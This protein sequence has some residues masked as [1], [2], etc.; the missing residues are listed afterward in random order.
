MTQKSQSVLSCPST[1][2]TAFWATIDADPDNDAIRLIFA[3]W[4][5]ERGDPRAAG[6]RNRCEQIR[7]IKE[8][9]PRLKNADGHFSYWGAHRHRY[10]LQPPLPAATLRAL[11]AHYGVRLPDDYF[12][13][14]VRIGEAGAG[15]SYGIESVRKVCYDGM[16][17][18]F[19]F[20]GTAGPDAA[21]D[22]QEDAAGCIRLAQHG[23]GSDAYLVISGSEAGKVWEFWGAADCLWHPTGMTFL[24]WYERWLDEGLSSAEGGQCH[25]L[26]R[27]G[28]W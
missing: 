25:E 28:G 10:Q 5:E 19:P 15:P 8:K 27:P 3:D 13:F 16:A 18:P 4:L 6:V 11:E 24:A 14:V 12:D 2:E 9:F 17:K 21:Y 23:C 20:D 7:R 22:L 26:W 1:E